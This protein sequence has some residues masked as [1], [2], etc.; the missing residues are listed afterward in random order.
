MPSFCTSSESTLLTTTPTFGMTNTKHAGQKKKQ[1]Y[2]LAI[3]TSMIALG[4]SYT[5]VTLTTNFYSPRKTSQHNDHLATF[6]PLP[7]GPT[8][9]PNP[10]TTIA[11]LKTQPTPLRTPS[12]SRTLSQ[13]PRQR[14]LQPLNESRADHSVNQPILCPNNLAVNHS[15]RHLV[16]HSVNS[17]AIHS[18]NH[19]LF[20]PH[21]LTGL[22]TLSPRHALEP[23]HPLLHAQEPCGLCLDEKVSWYATPNIRCQRA[24][25]ASCLAL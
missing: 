5:Q 13:S 12:V 15:F 25:A 10:L 24:G 17:P 16:K 4:K 11:Y 19:W 9:N 7:Y 3:S 8:N 2:Y 21:H 14:L 23:P 6:A 1:P 22:F 20:L 18:N